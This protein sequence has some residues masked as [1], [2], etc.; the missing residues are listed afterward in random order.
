MIITIDGPAGSGKSTVADK[1][2]ECIGFI[3]FNSGALFRA[4][5]AHLYKNN[6]NFSLLKVDTKIQDF[7]LKVKMINE[8]QHVY[9]NDI[10]YTPILRD[11]VISTLVPIAS[12]NAMVQQKVQAYLKEFCNTNNVVIE[13]RGIGSEVLPNAEFKFY[14]DCSI[15]ERA[16]RRFLEEQAKNSIITLEEIEKQIAERDHLDK[17]REITPLVIPNG[18]IIIDSTNLTIPQVVETMRNYLA[19]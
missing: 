14:L 17:T 13:G 7:N 5:T 16:K 19:K 9:I 8:N 15:K 4:I 2:A 18:A 12:Q 10:D 11:N 1:L 3:H 6:F